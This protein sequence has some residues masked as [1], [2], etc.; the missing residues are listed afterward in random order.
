M[1]ELLLDLGADI[2]EVSGDGRSALH[3]GAERGHVE[4]VRRLL[5]STPSTLVKLRSGSLWTALHFGAEQGGTEVVRL[6]L[7]VIS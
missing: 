7:E 6:L 2:L 3:F 1:V 4:V 5:K